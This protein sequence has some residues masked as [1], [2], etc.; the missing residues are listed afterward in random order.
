MLLHPSDASLIALVEPMMPLLRKETKR[1]LLIRLSA[2]P[3]AQQV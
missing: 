2:Q 1:A 3:Q